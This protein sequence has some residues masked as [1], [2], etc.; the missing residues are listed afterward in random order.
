MGKKRKVTG[1]ANLD[2]E[3]LLS[4]VFDR[5]AGSQES[6]TTPKVPGASPRKLQVKKQDV[7]KNIRKEKPVKTG[8]MVADLMN[9]KA[10]AR[11]KTEEGF[12]IYTEKELRIG[13][14]VCCRR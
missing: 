11:R 4:S 8:D 14:G 2:V 13:Q 9:T 3:G 10:G 1:V 6:K 12:N 5:R 7:E